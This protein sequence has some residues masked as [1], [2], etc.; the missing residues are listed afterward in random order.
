MVVGIP[1]WKLETKVANPGDTM[2]LN[3]NTYYWCPTHHDVVM[4]VSHKTYTCN[5]K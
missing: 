4:W 3:G 5:I 2:V 1:K